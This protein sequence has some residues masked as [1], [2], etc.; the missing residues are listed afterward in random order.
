MMLRKRGS[1]PSY[2][3]GWKCQR[4]CGTP[5]NQSIGKPSKVHL[6]ADSGGETYGKIDRCTGKARDIVKEPALR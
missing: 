1:V 5:Q 3:A 4:E 6:I 2:L